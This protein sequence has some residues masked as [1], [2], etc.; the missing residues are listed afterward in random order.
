MKKIE[1]M[2]KLIQIQNDRISTLELQSEELGKMQ[3]IIKKNP[4]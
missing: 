3:K 1:E 2:Q 4:K